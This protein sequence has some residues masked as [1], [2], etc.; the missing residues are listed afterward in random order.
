M[1]VILNSADFTFRNPEDDDIAI[2]EAGGLSPQ[3]TVDV[4]DD[5]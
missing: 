2:E 3:G 1:N 5:E 4:E